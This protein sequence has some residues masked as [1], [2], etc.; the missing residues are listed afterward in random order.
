MLAIGGM[1]A[2]LAAMPTAA[3]GATIT[4]TTTSDVSASECTL[5]DAITASNTNAPKGACPAG[6][7]APVTDSI[8]FALPT[9]AVI[10]LESALPAVAGPVSIAGPGAGALS[11]SGIDAFRVLNF[12]AAATASV[13]GL[14]VT[15]GK[16][17]EGAGIENNGTLTLEGVAVVGNVVAEEGGANTF[18][19]GG[20]IRSGNGSLTLIRSSVSGNSANAI[21]G[22]NQNGPEGG[23]IYNNSG[24]LRIVESTIS[25]NTAK[26]VAGAG[27]TT[28]AVGGG[29][30][31]ASGA[32]T[33]VRSTISGNSAAASGSTTFNT[34]QG[35]GVFNGNSLTTT[36]VVEG[37]TITGNVAVATGKGTSS[38]GG[39]MNTYGAS[40][41]ISGSTI[42]RNGAATGANLFDGKV[43]HVT[44]TIVA[45]PQ[46]GG[47]NCLAAVESAGY[48][49]EDG[50]SCG[51]TKVGDHSK[52]DPMLSPA[53]LADNGGPTPTIALLLGSPAIDQGLSGP[54]ETVDQRGLPRPVLYP[55]VP[56]TTPGSNGAD[57][58]AFELQP[59]APP[60]AAVVTPPPPIQPPI[61][62]V[63]PLLR[64]RVKC[65]TAAKPGG[66]GFRL[67]AVS[68]KP[69]KSARAGGR[70]GRAR[71]PVAETA[72]AK[73][74][75]GA[76]KTALVT[77]KP[78][79]KY[80]AKLAAASKILVREVETAKGT[81]L[82]TYR[83][84]SVVR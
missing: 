74:K 64:V 8:E 73:I 22:T 76:G 71:K 36:S 53:G 4:V 15:E 59:P 30:E 50:A 28:N 79:P 34:A 58:G 26:A 42:V 47:A 39:G 12:N 48:N 57:I 68:A 7:A 23:G 54:G 56:V 61:Q 77:L 20:G 70:H 46:G 67:Q 18:P 1:A 5:R 38:Q 40:A 16:A 52:T 35:G 14:T 33:V 29:I 21:G 72:V 75:V 43:P 37:S 13:S 2:L 32:L 55:G 19:Q 84:L 9:P 60:E 63:A 65:P 6:Q 81:T 44:D 62:R 69:P 10:V 24:A 3:M 45:A 31:N 17:S 66:C 78:K 49:I 83:R 82:T 41:T 51:F 11:I 25:G 27:G 80:A